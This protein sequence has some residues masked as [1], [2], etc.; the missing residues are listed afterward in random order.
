MHIITVSLYKSTVQWGHFVL[1]DTWL[2]SAFQ[3]EVCWYL[4]IMQ[5]HCTRGSKITFHIKRYVLLHT[6]THSSSCLM[7]SQREH[8]ISLNMPFPV[9][10]Q[11]AQRCPWNTCTKQL[12]KNLWVWGNILYV[13]FTTRGLESVGLHQPPST[14]T[15]PNPA[16]I[17]GTPKKC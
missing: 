4:L 16:L 15:M 17:L 6:C 2:H 12:I 5:Q 13:T 1:S 9:W 8:K 7:K 3:W 11:A 10:F 14:R